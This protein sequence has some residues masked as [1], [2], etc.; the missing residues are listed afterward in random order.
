MNSTTYT[1]E[2]AIEALE[3]GEAIEHIAKET[4]WEII[5]DCLVPEPG[6]WH[7]T[8]GNAEITIEASTAQQAAQEYVSGGT[9]DTSEETDWITVWA[10]REGI[11]S[12]GDL[13]HVGQEKH[14]VTLDPEV[15]K[16]SDGT[17]EHKWETPHEILGGLKENPGVWGHGG[18]IVMTEVCMR[19]GCAKITDT[20]A[21][22][23]HGRQGLTKASYEPGKYADA[24]AELAD[25][26]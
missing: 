8:D 9:W 24:V 17:R 1:K 20:W 5:D 19:C 23:S 22:D 2:T 18:G 4:G 3:N 16:C 14:T 21:Q 15:P 25:E 10:W 12:D 13:V 7:A 26:D 11:D 6:I